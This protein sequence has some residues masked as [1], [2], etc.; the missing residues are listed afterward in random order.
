MKTS[1]IPTII[2]LLAVCIFALARPIFTQSILSV[3]VPLPGDEGNHY[4]LPMF[5]AKPWERLSEIHLARQGYLYGPSLLGNTS[6][7]PTGI[8]GDAMVARDRA[9]WFKDVEYVTENVYPELEKAAT[10]LFRVSSLSY[11]ES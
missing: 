3:P 1:A 2:S 5:D 7:F 4:S 9:R 8:L 6:A 10:A 11:A